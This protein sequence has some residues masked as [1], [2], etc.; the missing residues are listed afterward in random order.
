MLSKKHLY[1]VLEFPKHLQVSIIALVKLG[2]ACA[3]EVAAVT[4]KS[5]AVESH[6]LNLL[7]VMRIVRKGHR[8]SKV[9][10][11]VDLEAL[12]W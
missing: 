11:Q 1:K 5:R 9:F 4:G 8:C 12:A 10:F 2:S 7:T 6:Y 3:Q